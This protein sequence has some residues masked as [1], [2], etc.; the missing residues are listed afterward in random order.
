MIAADPTLIGPPIDWFALSPLLVLLGAAMVL[1]IG[2]AF[3]PRG[4]VIS[5]RCSPRRR[6]WHR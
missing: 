1:L 4:R 2:G 3:A 5:T 6:A